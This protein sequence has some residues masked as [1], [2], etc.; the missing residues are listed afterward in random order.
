MFLHLEEPGINAFCV[1]IFFPSGQN[2]GHSSYDML[3]QLKDHVAQVNLLKTYFKATKWLVCSPIFL[4]SR[5]T[6][7]LTPLQ[8]TTL[9]QGAA[10]G[11]SSVDDVLSRN[12]SEN[13]LK[14]GWAPRKRSGQAYVPFVGVAREE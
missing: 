10:V 7:F 6:Y 8:V 3:E 13:S 1:G 14:R 5:Q 12:F 2:C 4:S 9:S 11:R